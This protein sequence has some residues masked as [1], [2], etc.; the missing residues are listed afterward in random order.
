MNEQNANKTVKLVFG[1]IFIII[2]VFLFI[3]AMTVSAAYALGGSSNG[4]S[5][6]AGGI[7]TSLLMIVLGII[8]LAT[9]KK[10]TKGIK[11]TT[12]VLAAIAI[13][14]CIGGA[15]GFEDLYLYAIFIFLGT[16]FSN[17]PTKN[18]VQ[19]SKTS[20]TKT[21]TN[22]SSNTADEIVKLKKLM[23]D[24]VITKEEF[25]AKKKQLLN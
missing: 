8:F 21:V 18:N 3:Q 19:T 22:P 23:D 12:W 25:E 14:I 4:V 11:I 20:N 9:Q 7:V 17:R 13:L 6:G 1:I 24:G 5:S 2:A 16:F 10:I 15:D